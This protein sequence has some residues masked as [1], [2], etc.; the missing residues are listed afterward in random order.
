MQLSREVMNTIERSYLVGREL[1]E[2]SEVIYEKHGVKLTVNQ[3]RE[4]IDNNEVRWDEKN[5]ERISDYYA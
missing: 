1:G 2:T 4:I 3:L 5:F